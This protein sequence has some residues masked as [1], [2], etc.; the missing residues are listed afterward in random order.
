MVINDNKTMVVNWMLVVIK[1]IVVNVTMM[2]T[3]MVFACW[4]NCHPTV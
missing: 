1:M 4:D 3:L 2:T